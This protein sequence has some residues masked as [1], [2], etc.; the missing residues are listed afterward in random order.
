MENKRPARIE[1]RQASQQ[2]AGAFDRLRTI[3]MV[4]PVMNEQKLWPAVPLAD[5]PLRVAQGSAGSAGHRGRF[6][7]TGTNPAAE[8]E[9]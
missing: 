1:F 8:G 5:D 4:D 9:P 6:A 7:Q 2:G 3:G